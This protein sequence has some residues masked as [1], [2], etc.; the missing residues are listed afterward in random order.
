VENLTLPFDRRVW[1]E[2]QALRDAG[3][4]V[5]VICPTGPPWV[6]R[7]EN[8]E[9]VHIYRYPAP[10][11]TPN[12]F[13]YLR[14][15]LHCWLWT[16]WLT[17]R[18]RREQ[19][20]DLIHACNPPDTFFAIGWWWRLRG[21]K[22]VF[23]QHDVCPEVYLSRFGAGH[24][25][26]YR[27]LL[28]LERLTYAASDMVIATNLSYREVARRRGNVGDE[29][30]AVVRSAPDLTR[31]RQV[32]PCPELRR[33][34]RHLVC[35]LGVMAPQDGVDYLLRAIRHVVHQRRRE[36]IH[37]ALIGSGDSFEDLKRL[38][39]ELEIEPWVEFTGRIPDED[40]MRYLSSCDLG[41]APDPLNPLNDIST[42][43]KVLEYMATGRALVAY[44]LKE[45]RFSAGDGALYAEPNR[46]D[47][48][49]DKMLELLDDPERRAAMGARNQRRLREELAWDRSAAALLEAY[50]RVM[51]RGTPG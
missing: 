8:L 41:A 48:F 5:S 22:F 23:D 36:D 28:L 27:A 39:R 17:F 26:L 6:R 1:L 20:F 32:E 16:F 35:Y 18:V 3:W 14:E 50:T 31:F 45:T 44:D 40:V 33:G 37:F 13:A 24:G 9:G 15:F 46:E 51:G 2:S 12:A 29:R 19:G 11:P 25:L 30:A 38:S 10:P 42:M 34:R 4:R 21:V 7:Y 43:N 49:G 47:D